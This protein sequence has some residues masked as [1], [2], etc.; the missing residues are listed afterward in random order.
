MKKLIVIFLILFASITQVYA[1]TWNECVEKYERA[2]QFND[3]TRLSYI[4]LKSTRNCIIKFKDFLIQNPNPDFS[5]KSMSENI[6]MLNNYLNQLLPD[7]NYNKNNLEQ[8]PKYLNIDSQNPIKNQEYKY[9]I[10]FDGCNGVH[11]NNKIYTAKHCKI[12]KSKNIH[13][14]LNYI[15]T[16]NTSKLKIEKLDTSKKGTFKYYSMSKE[17]MFYN[18]LLQEKNCKFYKAK[19]IPTG[20][21]TSLDLTDL[22]KK[23]EIRSNCLAIPSNSGGGVFQ[24][25]KLVGIISKTVFNNNRFLYSVVEPIIPF[26]PNK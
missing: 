9:F 1:F 17:G 10:K 25:G 21:N 23:E 6:T 5:V 11:A 12:E 26:S 16:K 20:V 14:D 4:Y 19:N 13:Y 8:I 3:H 2:K 7:Y 18:V 15:D 22:K 24:E